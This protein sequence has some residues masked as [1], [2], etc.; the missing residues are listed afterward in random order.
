MIKEEGK[1]ILKEDSEELLKKK[2]KKENDIL[3]NMFIKC[4]LFL[5]IMKLN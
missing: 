1:V 3:F 2:I 4:Y 5:F